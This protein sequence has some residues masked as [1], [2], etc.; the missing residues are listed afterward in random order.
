MWHVAEGIYK[1]DE[2]VVGA[3]AG[4]GQQKKRQD[5]VFFSLFGTRL[6]K[7]GEKIRRAKFQ[8]EG[9][10]LDDGLNT[11]ILLSRR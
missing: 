5:L 1:G 8:T 4:E 2:V 11:T 9:H 10:P 3:S 7:K 6:R